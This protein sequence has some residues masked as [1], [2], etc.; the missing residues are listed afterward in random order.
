MIKIVNN[1]SSSSKNTFL[2]TSQ[3]S[4]S[5]DYWYVLSLDGNLKYILNLIYFQ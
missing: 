4:V 3:S 5:M 1:D 2:T